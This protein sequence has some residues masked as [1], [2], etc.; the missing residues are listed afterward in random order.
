MTPYTPQERKDAAGKVRDQWN[1]LSMNASNTLMY[2][3]IAIYLQ[4]AL[5][6]SEKEKGWLTID[7]EEA[8]GLLDRTHE[9]LRLIRMKDSNAVYDTLIR[10]QANAFLTAHKEAGNANPNQ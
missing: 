9:E 10:L 3:E 4:C 5:T 1:S 8:V 2:L 6:R 7:L